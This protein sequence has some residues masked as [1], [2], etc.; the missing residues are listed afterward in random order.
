V[1]NTPIQYSVALN[2]KYDGLYDPTK[3]AERI[4]MA[5]NPTQDINLLIGHEIVHAATLDKARIY[6]SRAFSRLT[7]DEISVFKELDKIRNAMIANMGKGNA[8]FSEIMNIAD[9]AVR[10]EVA[11]QAVA[12]GEIGGELY[13]LTN[14]AE[15]LA[16][17]INNK[18]FQKALD[19]VD[20]NIFSQIWNLLLKL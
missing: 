13:A 8:R 11:A 4:V 12:N 1:A 20:P 6:D 15:F 16:N 19:S 17:S 7:S 9:A 14:M 5:Q 2:G 3:N 18:E 10:A